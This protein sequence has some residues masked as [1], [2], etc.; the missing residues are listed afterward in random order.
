MDIILNFIAVIF[1]SISIFEL[2]RLCYIM[3]HTHNITDYLCVCD[4]FG[5]YEQIAEYGRLFEADFNELFDKLQPGIHYRVTTHYKRV[6]ERAIADGKIKLICPVK[7]LK[8]RTLRELKPLLG[9][10]DYRL[11][12]K[13][14]NKPA[15]II[16]YYLTNHQKLFTI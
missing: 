4:W 16:F 15:F 14:R 2:Y 1:F 8:N 12:R 5:K 9:R 6:M 10:M 7:E 13:H 11:A 3:K